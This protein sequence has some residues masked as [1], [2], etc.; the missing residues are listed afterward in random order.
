MPAAD[1]LAS[2]PTRD[3]APRSTLEIVEFT[4]P[5]CPFAWSAEPIRRRLDW[6][7][8]EQLRWE[9]CMVGLAESARD[10][11][12]KGFTPERQA[13]S[14]RRLAHEHQMPIDSSPRSRVTATVPACRAVVATR[15]HAPER[16]RDLLRALRILHFSGWLLD[17]P[18]TILAA[19]QR[20]GVDGDALAAWLDE[21]ETE[22]LL[23][24][25]LALARDPSRGALALAHKLA[26]TDD[27]G[28]RYTCPSYELR[29]S[30]D[31]LGL[32]VPGFQPL[33][34]YEVAIANLQPQARRRAAPRDVEEVLAWAGEPLASAEVA[35]VCAIEPEDA[36]ERLGR[37]AS[38]EHI[39]FEG[40]WRLDGTT[41]RA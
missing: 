5:G 11:E 25:D 32:A 4:D 10:Y 2:A 34:A 22:E 6:L 15:R 16:E 40:L 13:A 12:E 41:S 17:E 36:R 9:L 30:S 28:H 7:Y 35:A 33:A 24:R 1:A 21:P 8:G 37:V 38:E 27:G 20:A 14:F 31:G 23:R 39:G 29:R 18:E 3:D 19:G 26:E